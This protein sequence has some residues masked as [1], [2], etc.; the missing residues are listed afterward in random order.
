MSCKTSYDTITTR[1]PVSAPIPYGTNRVAGSIKWAE[2]Y[3]PLNLKLDSNIL[4]YYNATNESS[5]GPKVM[6]TRWDNVLPGKNLFIYDF[7]DTTTSEQIDVEDYDDGEL[8]IY[9]IEN[10][11]SSVSSDALAITQYF[12]VRRNAG[13]SNEYLEIIHADILVNLDF[14]F[15]DGGEQNRY[16]LS[17]VILHELG[18]FLGLGHNFGKENSVMD[19]YIHLGEIKRALY[20]VDIQSLK[21]N[22]PNINESNHLS[23]TTSGQR[24]TDGEEIVRGIIEQR[25]DGNCVH[26]LKY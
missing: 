6:A 8:G 10:W 13:T 11:F 5:H 22:Y 18:H 1:L 12:A 15:S 16:D 14:P 20:T 3:F 7:P 24:P 19:P 17:S 25:T 2:S 9:G 23:I 21:E 4:N 26:H